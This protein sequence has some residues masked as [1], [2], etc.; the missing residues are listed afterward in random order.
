MVV[1]LVLP[2]FSGNV[3]F[4]KGSGVDLAWCMSL[5]RFAP[6]GNQYDLLLSLIKFNYESQERKLS[7]GHN[8]EITT[9]TSPPLT[10]ARSLTPLL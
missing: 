9:A 4:V 3:C 7:R 6:S 2:I 8:S 1:L 5:P 10:T